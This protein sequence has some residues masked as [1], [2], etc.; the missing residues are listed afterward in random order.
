MNQSVLSYRFWALLGCSLT[1]FYVGNEGSVLFYLLLVY[2]YVYQWIIAQFYPNCLQFM[3]LYLNT[4]L[5]RRTRR[6]VISISCF[7]F[8]PCRDDDSCLFPRMIFE[9]YLS[10]EK[11]PGYVGIKT[12]HFNNPCSK[13]HDS[14]KSKAFFC[15]AHLFNISRFNRLK[16]VDWYY[17]LRK[18]TWILC[19]L[20]QAVSGSDRASQWWAMHAVLQL[21]VQKSGKLTSWGW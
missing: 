9:I 6:I 13:K 5:S 11:H 14:M 20:S 2:W 18:T 4:N 12:K 10:N 21:M 7:F 16:L 3:N 17:P 8:K 19:I 1:M 15:V